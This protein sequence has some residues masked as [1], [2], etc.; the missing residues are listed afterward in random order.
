MDLAEA[1]EN[2][3]AGDSVG[4]GVSFF[5]LGFLP[6]RL[7]EGLRPRNVALMRTWCLEKIY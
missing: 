5:F 3:G 1:L 6:G 7:E 4:G 2:V